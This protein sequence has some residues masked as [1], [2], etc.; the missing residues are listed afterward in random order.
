VDDL[1]DAAARLRDEASVASEALR[2]PDV[3]I[4]NPLDYAWHM[5]DAF[6]RRYGGSAP[7]DAILV[8]MNPGPWGMLQTGIP[9][10][11]PATV[12]EWMGLSG[13]V[14]SPPPEALHPSRPVLGMGSSRREV[15]GTRLYG[16]ARA[17]FGGPD[18]FFGRVWVVNYCPLAI[19]DAAGANVTPPQ[20]PAHARRA[21]AGPSDRHLASVIAILRPRVVV[22]VGTYAFA[23]VEDVLGGLP[24][25][26]RPMAANML[27]PSPANPQANK[28]WSDAAAA[29]LAAVGVLHER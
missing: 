4:Y 12:R 2:S 24:E 5:H 11:D 3:Y 1:L 16:M 28:G 6:I 25:S 26:G 7:R 22:G 15:S 9:F 27:H 20:L 8:G 13:E 18:A 10:G 19:F 21:L 14:G 29:Q 17:R 23:R